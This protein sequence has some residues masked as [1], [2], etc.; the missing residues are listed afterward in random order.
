MAQVLIDNDLCKKCGI[1][2]N[3]CP[4]NVYSFNEL[5]GPKA[6]RPEDCIECDI[7]VKMCPDFAIKIKGE[8][9]DSK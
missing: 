9:E 2:F 4:K 5:D 1:C 3:V 7:C 8:K 6:E